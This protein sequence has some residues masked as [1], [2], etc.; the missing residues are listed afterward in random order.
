MNK[1]NYDWVRWDRMRWDFVNSLMKTVKAHS[2][3]TERLTCT[4]P[5]CC[6]G[7]IESFSNFG[8]EICRDDSGVPIRLDFMLSLYTLVKNKMQD[9][10]VM[11]SDYLLY[12]N[13]HPLEGA[14]E[15]P[16]AVGEV[17]HSEYF[18]RGAQDHADVHFTQK[19]ADEI[20][21]LL[22]A[23]VHL[24]FPNEWLLLNHKQNLANHHNSS[25]KDL[26][27]GWDAN[28]RMAQLFEA[29]GYEAPLLSVKVVEDLISDEDGSYARTSHFSFDEDSDSWNAI[30]GYHLGLAMSD[31][32]LDRYWNDFPE[33]PDAFV[34][35]EH[36]NQAG[37]GMGFVFKSPTLFVSQQ[38]WESGA[39]GLWN[40]C[41]QS[42]NKH[43]ASL[44]N[45]SNSSDSAMV[46]F[47]DYREDAYIVSS[48]EESWDE[49]SPM[50][51]VMGP[52]PKGFGIVGVWTNYEES[53]YTPHP[54]DDVIRANWSAE[55]TACARYLKDCL[56]AVAENRRSF[57]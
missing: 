7:F 34:Y 11:V 14:M 43:L 18:S 5:K 37:T 8:I 13:G 40:R 10:M 9:G 39:N 46:V 3:A 17:I 33:R 26:P 36:G 57:S 44:L 19:P 22:Y 15:V 49:Y 12:G 25:V 29:A 38:V 48:V 28:A 54:L 41:T 42:F 21:E 56:E 35:S 20:R 24:T 53:R 6:L 52:L 2:D 23:F 16:M 30:A 1:P 31:A 51:A 50:S 4:N 27:F 32:S 55:I 45:E 47:S